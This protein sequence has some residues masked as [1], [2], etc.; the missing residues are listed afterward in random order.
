MGFSPVSLKPTR[1]RLLIFT[2][3]YFNLYSSYYFIKEIK[4]CIGCGLAHG[5]KMPKINSISQSWHFRRDSPSTSDLASKFFNIRVAL[6][7][8]GHRLARLDRRKLHQARQLRSDLLA[9]AHSVGWVVVGL[10][11]DFVVW[12]KN[13]YVHGC[14]ASKQRVIW[15]QFGKLSSYNTHKSYPAKS[16][17]NH[18]ISYQTVSY[19]IRAKHTIYDNI[20]S[21]LNIVFTS[22]QTI[23]DIISKQKNAG[24]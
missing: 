10:F 3:F 13:L 15:L 1:F 18:I 6:V 11:D 24:Y 7:K 2:L 5:I 21:Y 17:C 20:K 22:Y 12:H 4:R 23:F 16:K 9:I 14:V 19:D 8:N